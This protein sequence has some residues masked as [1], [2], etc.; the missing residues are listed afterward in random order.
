MASGTW[1]LICEYVSFKPCLY[2][3]ELSLE[4]G[5]PSIPSHLL[6]SV[7]MKR[8]VPADRVKVDLA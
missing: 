3:G 6:P 2:E 4:G 5:L 7:Y 1:Y 8:V